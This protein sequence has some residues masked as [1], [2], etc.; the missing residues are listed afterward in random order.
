[1]VNIDNGKY[2]L[3]GIKSVVEGKCG[4]KTC[5]NFSTKQV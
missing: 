2:L 1:M 4:W 5:I 3:V